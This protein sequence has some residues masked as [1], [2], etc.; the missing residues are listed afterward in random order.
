MRLFISTYDIS[1][2]ILE[3]PQFHDGDITLLYMSKQLCDINK[4]YGT[5]LQYM[6]LW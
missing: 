2:L 5:K 4:M 1:K 3:E 6:I